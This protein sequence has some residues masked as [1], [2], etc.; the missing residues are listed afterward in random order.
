MGCGAGEQ[1]G[2]LEPSSRLR[3][4]L[5]P[6]DMADPIGR[7][8]SKENCLLLYLFIEGANK[9]IV[10]HKISGENQLYDHKSKPFKLVV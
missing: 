5:P 2:L 4:L 1:D 6:E 7:A 3:V 9:L 10:S 8:L